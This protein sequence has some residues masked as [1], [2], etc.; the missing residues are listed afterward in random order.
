MTG[1][2]TFLTGP[3]WSGDDGIW[4]RIGEHLQYSV[5]ALLVA[6]VVALPIGAVIGHTGRGTTVAVLVVNVIRAIPSLGLLTLLVLWG[7]DLIPN[8]VGLY[9]PSI[10][11]LVV[12]G[13][14]PILTNTYSGIRA[15]DP[16]A[17]DAARG[18][19]MTGRQVL[20]RVELPVAAPL[21]VAGIRSAYLQIVATAT[22]LALVLTL[23]GLGRFILDGPKAPV[24]GYGIMAGGAVLV[25]LLAIL[26]DRVIALLGR[27][28]ISP[29][30]R[31]RPSRR[32]RRRTTSATPAPAVAAPH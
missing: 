4:V 18:M 7:L 15:V 3:N 32:R 17:R 31:T 24:N 28:V 11:V 19:G 23:N 13:I 27:S 29:G 16:A 2:W 12:L 6:L 14:P 10:L 20:F 25:A 21:I 9:L 5:L 8:R 30:L 22:I 26:G 1:V